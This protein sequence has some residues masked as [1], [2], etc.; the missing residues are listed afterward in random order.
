MQARMFYPECWDGKSLDS[1][2]HSSHVRY[3][4]NN[5]CPASHPILLP[6]LK[7]QV[8]YNALGQYSISE[9]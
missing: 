1:E 6:T 4:N 5:G 7:F 3:M 2:D 8:H 9:R